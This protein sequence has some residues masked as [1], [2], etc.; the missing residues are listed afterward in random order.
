MEMVKDCPLVTIIC[1][2]YQHAKFIEQALEGILCQVTD[3][4][5][6][7]IVHDDAST[8]GTVTILKRYAA[9]Y[10][11]IISLV[12]EEKNLFSKGINLWMH[13]VFP[14]IRGK[15]VCFCEGD[16]Y[17]TDKFKIQKQVKLLEKNKDASLCFSKVLV[18][19][20]DQ[21]KE[22]FIFP[23][24][25]FRFNK[26][27]LEFQDIAKRNFIQTNSVMYRWA[28]SKKEDIPS[29]PVDILP[30]DW[31]IHLLHAKCGKIYFQDEVTGVYRRHNSGLWAGGLGDPGW[32]RR[33]GPPHIKFYKEIETR[34]NISKEEE[35]RDLFY[36][37]YRLAK[38]ANDHTMLELLQKIVGEKKFRE[39]VAGAAKA[40]FVAIGKYI[41]SLLFS[42]LCF[43]ETKKKLKIISDRYKIF[44]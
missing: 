30:A 9:A 29:F 17:W 20:E 13:K 43:G 3:F 4:P 42:L 25:S 23:E 15:Y 40:R 39:L 36:R 18:H 24:D 34:F 6:E 5:I 2:T 31:Y 11:K 41:S 22:D 19:W 7:I 1:I 10:P 8:D 37:C 12:L 33:C 21:S 26:T 32:L 38:Q 16:D 44:I 14:L 35:I 27:I 28:L